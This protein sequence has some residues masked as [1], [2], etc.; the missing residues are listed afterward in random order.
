MTAPRTRRPARG[1][2]LIELLAAA[3]IL[4]I[5]ATVAVPVI[6]TTMR[7]EREHQLRTA[8]RDIREAIDAYKRAADAGKI[9]V[10]SDE[11]GYPHSLLDLTAGVPDATASDGRRLYFLRRVP[12]DPFVT[13]LAV[14]AIDSWGKRSYLSPPDAPVA[15]DDVFDVYSTSAQ[16]GMNGVPYR[17]W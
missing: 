9:V 17:E 6:E 7:R 13:N 5:L 1:F 8:L 10:K 16:K 4:G 12:R 15:G 2:S 3:A 14:T 11:S